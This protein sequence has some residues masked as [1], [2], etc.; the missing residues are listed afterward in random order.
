MTTS[1]LASCSEGSKPEVRESTTT[2][3]EGGSPGSD[4]LIA[5][6]ETD[7]GS[8]RMRLRPDIA[9]MSTANFINLTNR[10]FY[11]GKEV[12]ASNRISTSYGMGKTTPLYNVVNEYSPKL[13]F[14][15]PGVVAWTF[16]DTKVGT[17][18]Q[19]SH[20]TRFFISK[21]PNDTWTY[22]FCPFAEIIEGQET[23]DN[24]QAGDWIRSVRI[25]GDADPLMARYRDSIE[26]WNSALRLSGH[27][28]PDE[29]QGGLNEIPSST[30]NSN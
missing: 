23:V 27:F 21:E 5:V 24:A 6:V 17:T 9:P 15:R 18:N 14:D 13:V 4:E 3:A 29:R 19:I 28:S 12:V 8:F 20:P 16:Q 10:G 30:I 22:T 26:K 25:I 1:L 11:H 7:R 2:S